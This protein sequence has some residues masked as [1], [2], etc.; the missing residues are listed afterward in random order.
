MQEDICAEMFITL[1]FTLAKNNTNIK[2]G[3]IITLWANHKMEQYTDTDS[4]E[5]H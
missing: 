1:L 3:G 5:K 4:M 2:H